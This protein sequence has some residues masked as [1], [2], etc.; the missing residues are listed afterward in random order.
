MGSE[1]ITLAVFDARLQ[2]AVTSIQ[3]AGGPAQ[4]NSA[5]QTGLRA[6]VLRSLILDTVIAQEATALGI[7]ATEADVDAQVSAAERQSGG[8]SGLQTALAEAGG[9][10]AQLRDEIRSQLNEQRLEDHFAKQRVELVEQQLAS[11]QSFASLAQSSS[12][13]TGT[14]SKGGDLG[15]LTSADLA[16]DDPAFVG[17]V[18]AL[19]IGAYTTAPVHDSGG[20]DIV[21]LYATTPATWSVRHILVA[22]PTPYTVKGRPAWFS[23]AL[24]STVAQLCSQHRIHVFI[25]D[26]GGDPCSG[27]PLATPAPG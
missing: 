24:F 23:E 21:E 5:M 15:A 22:A 10:I 26:A 14:S 1:A 17:A 13:D 11:G 25:S 6:S 19:H 9:S 12:D 4:S 20:Y 18:R 8:A 16:G 7:E 2:S 27:A 3:Q